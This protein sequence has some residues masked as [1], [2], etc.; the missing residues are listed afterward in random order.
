MKYK[1]GDTVIIQKGKTDGN[2]RI[3]W[4]NEMN[5]YVGTS[6][7]ITEEML[8]DVGAYSP[9]Y[10]IVYKDFFWH[11]KWLKPKRNYDKLLE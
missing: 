6:L 4:V 7:K 11:E 1:A 5:K 10:N 2:L 9:Q 8:S 3:V